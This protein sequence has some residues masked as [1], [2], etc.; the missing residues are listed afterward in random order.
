MLAGLSDA[1]AV[2]SPAPTAASPTAPNPHPPLGGHAADGTVPGG[3]QLE[4][5]SL[6]VPAGS[7]KLPKNLTAKSWVLADLDSGQVLAAVSIPSPKSG[8]IASM[9]GLDRSI[10]GRYPPGSTFKIV[11]AA[12]ALADGF[13]DYTVVCNHDV[14][15]LIWKF[16]GKT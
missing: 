11:T 5:R 2:P 10:D 15:N 6:I 7:P 4:S 1:A 9:S 14:E 12:S 16:D 13:A 3:A 8:S